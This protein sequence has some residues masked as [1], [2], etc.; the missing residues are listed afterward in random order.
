MK[1]IRSGSGPSLGTVRSGI[2]AS[3]GNGP[4]GSKLKVAIVTTSFP[5]EPGL[6]SGI[7]IEKL[8]Q[9]LGRWVD[10]TVV[11][12]AFWNSARSCQARSSYR[13]RCFR[14]AP[15]PWQRIAHAPGGIPVT[16]RRQPLFYG[17]L[18]LFFGS[19]FLACCGIARKAS[20]IHANWSIN[21]LVCGIAGWLAGVPVV[22][23]LRGS[24][25]NCHRSTRLNR[26][27]LGACLSLNDRI[28]T[29]SDAIRIRL[30]NE[31]PQYTAKLITIPNGVDQALLEFPLARKS[32]SVCRIVSVGNL[33]ANK[34]FATILEAMKEIK[35]SSIHL[36]IVGEGV[37]KDHLEMITERFGLSRRVRFLGALSPDSVALD[38]GEADVFVLASFSEGRPNVVL[39][40]MAAGTPVI[41]SNLEG[42]RELIEDGKTG[43]LFEPGNSRQLA[44]CI[45]KL[46]SDPALRLKLAAA[47]RDF[48][49]QNDLLWSA[50][51]RRYLALY[52]ELLGDPN[53]ACAA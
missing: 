51:A 45:G 2:S 12:P 17:L 27:A 13:L 22:T 32:A 18:P 40:A 8:V 41:A 38:L 15:K 31:F 44:D 52:H 35:D 1:S 37:E 48:I 49:V 42:V 24:D 5:V 4:H 23:T 46:A 39:E 25:V 28:V 29:V 43:L 20:L 50:T 36:N 10:V 34:G 16:L 9:A 21:G 3:Y 11:A 19:M 30:A 26:L 7:F 14:Y 53:P 33:V 47:A 6:I